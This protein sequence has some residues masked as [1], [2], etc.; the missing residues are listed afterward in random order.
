MKT[1]VLAIAF[2]AV[3]LV[4][5]LMSSVPTHA[6]SWPWDEPDPIELV[7]RRTE[8]S[9]TYAKPGGKYALEISV[10]AIHYK[11]SWGEWQD[12]DE[13]YSEP[14]TDGFSA[15]FTKCLYYTR[16]ADS[17][18]RRVYPDR[19]DLSYWIELGNPFPNNNPT[20]DKNRWTWDFPNASV[21]IQVQGSTLKFSALLKN[22]NAPSSMSI[23]FNVQGITRQAS[24]LYHNGQVVAELRKPFAIDAG[25]NE[26][27]VDV[28]FGAGKITLDLD[29]TG[30]TYPIEI[31]PTLDL[32]VGASSDDCWVYYDGAAWALNLTGLGQMA[33]YASATELK[34]GGGM[35]FLNVTIPQGTTIDA[36]Y[37]TL[38]CRGANAQ[39][40]INTRITGEDVDDAATFSDIA[41]YQARRGTIV[42]GA[43]DD[44]ITTAQV[45]W[46][47]IPEWTAEEEGAD[48]TSPEIKAIIQEIVDRGGWAS[49][50]DLVLF[51][52]DHDARGDQVTSH[53]RQGYAYDASTT[54]CA[55]LSIEGTWAPTV[56]TGA[57]TNVEETTATL[58]GDITALNDGNCTVRGFEWD[59]DSGAP[60]ANDWHEDGDFGVGAFT[61]NLTSLTEDGRYYYRAYATNSEGTG[62]GSEV[63]FKTWGQVLWFQPVAIISGTALPDREG[64]QDGVITWG[65]NPG[66]V[67]VTLEGL[68]RYDEDIDTGTEL[69][70]PPVAPGISEPADMFPEEE[71]LAA[72]GHWLYPIIKPI[73]D[74]IP[75][76]TPIQW[77]WLW[78]AFI[79]VLL[80][81]VTTQRFGNNLFMTGVVTAG[82][83]AGCV[84]M[85]WLPFWFIIVVVMMLAG[86]VAWERY[87]P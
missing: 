46:D 62:Y 63:Q 39:V 40:V 70:P 60:Y 42:D 10:G 18:L 16:I 30:L 61:H 8:N 33:G 2:T 11:D 64:N 20:K 41:D 32:Q 47:A 31:D 9:K 14:D 83:I 22:E 85:S 56:T 35:R 29:T 38:T 68:L 75:A 43:N 45:D 66:G 26:R 28:S 49:G 57:A 15:K 71:D 50:N 58:N 81:T 36:A 21:S 34:D 84:A 6:W 59:I 4:A 80:C 79:F 87:T 77:V 54:K 3:L 52:D 19:N 73:T 65:A 69:V 76:E 55:K 5:F 12:I 82:A 7:D 67:T 25:G 44:Y 51:W 53:Y 48:T 78:F 24:L 72:T 23:P 86:L 27:K 74:M 13:T 37:L 1:K 17:G